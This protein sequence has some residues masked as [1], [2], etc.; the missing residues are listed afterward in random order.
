MSSSHA[1]SA[2]ANLASPSRSNPSSQHTRTASSSGLLST[3]MASPL[4]LFSPKATYGQVL[5]E[6]DEI[7]PGESSKS[8]LLDPAGCKR[9]EL[10]IGGM[11]V[12]LLLRYR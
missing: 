10:R 12:S 7:K 3:I 9:V 4:A 2:S 1:R 8:A 11:T 6:D 5:L